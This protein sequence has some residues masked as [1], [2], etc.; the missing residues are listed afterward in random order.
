VPIYP[1]SNVSLVT[2]TG[3]WADLSDGGSASG[4]V[5]FEPTAVLVDGTS[6]PPLI[7]RPEPQTAILDAT[8]SIS[9]QL[10]AT[11]DPDVS[12]TGW[13][14]RVTERIQGQQTNRI[15]LINLPAAQTPVDLSTIAP[16]A[17]PPTLVRYILA[18]ARG[19]PNGVASLDATGNVPVDQL[20]NAGG[21]GGSGTPSGTVVAETSYGQ[22]AAAGAATAYSRGDHTHGSPS[23]TAATPAASAVV[24]TAAVGTATTPARADHR[25]A[26][27]GFGAVTAQTTYAAASSNGTAATVAHSDHA[28]GTPALS[29]VAATTS[30]VGD[31]ATIGAAATPARADHAH[32]REAFGSATAQTSYGLASADGSAATVAHSD[33]A[34]GTPALTSSAPTTSAVVDVANVGTGT[35]PARSDHTHGREGFGAISA[36]T[37]YGLASANGAAVTVARS[38]HTHGSPSLTSSAASAS[39]VGDTAAVGV[40]TTPARSDHV[41]GR[42]AF[43]AAT[44]QTSYGLTSGNGSAATVAH[45]DHTHG[46][47]ALSAVAATTS[48]VGDAAA[49]GTGTTPARSDHTHGR[50]GFGAVT[51]QTSYGAASANGAA[52]TVARSDHAHGTPPLPYTVLAFSQAG[53]VTVGVGKARIYNDSGRTLTIQAVRASAGTAPTGASL[54][55]DINKDGTTIFTTQGNRPAI[56][57]GTNTSGKVTNMDVTTIADGSYFSVDV[58]QVGSTVAGSDLTVQ[59]WAA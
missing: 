7:M 21:G 38:D 10:M 59:I 8:G 40:G 9:V 51:A 12:P 41:H 55:V 27:E 37:S 16:L 6:T 46:T 11:D 30:A 43:G 29:A 52:T 20:A 36:E 22:T 33:H 58:D 48:A 23:L 44:A 26:R 35:T 2:V 32:G 14:W 5:D 31:T 54:I 24:D 45:S 47:P 19:A 39:A 42:E 25:H 53:T 1:P 3:T 17:Q 15:Y 13:A 50:E 18:S 28:H 57:A 34:H 56:A 4:E 49:V